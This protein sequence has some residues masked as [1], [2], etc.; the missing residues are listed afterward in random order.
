MAMFEEPRTQGIVCSSDKETLQ[1]VKDMGYHPKIA[2]K[3]DL[4]EDNQYLVQQWVLDLIDGD[5][6]HIDKLVAPKHFRDDPD[7]QYATIVQALLQDPPRRIR[8]RYLFWLRVKN[9]G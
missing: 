4:D 5:H 8:R 2:P 3:A 7:A 1:A 6:T 9:Q